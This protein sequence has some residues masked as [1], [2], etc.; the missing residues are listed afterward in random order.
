[1]K[2][3]LIRL[4]EVISKVGFQK[5]YIWNCIKEGTF[6]KQIKLGARLSVWKES[7]ID[8]WIAEKIAQ[9]EDG[10]IIHK[11]NPTGGDSSSVCPNKGQL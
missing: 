9:A 4:P 8:S 11:Q 6:P 5:T 3:R 2:E 7:D 1:M 10:A